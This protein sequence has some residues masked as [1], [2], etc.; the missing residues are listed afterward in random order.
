MERD[1]DP[2]EVSSAIIQG[3]SG[4]GDSEERSLQFG[5]QLWDVV[6]Q[7]DPSWSDVLEVIDVAEKDGKINPDFV[8]RG[9]LAAALA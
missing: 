9:Y 7:E 6:I 4:I 5:S 8:S 3:L 2:T 1:F